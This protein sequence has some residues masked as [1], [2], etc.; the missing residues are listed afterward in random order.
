M[1]MAQMPRITGG[2]IGSLTLTKSEWEAI[3][4]RDDDRVRMELERLPGE[5]NRADILEGRSLL[6]MLCIDISG[7]TMG[8]GSKKW[9]QAK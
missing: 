4:D 8:R 1:S 5:L 6:C 3:E 2:L 7:G 9:T